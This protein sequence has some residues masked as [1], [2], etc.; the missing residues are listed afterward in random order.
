MVYRLYRVRDVIRIPPDKFNKP[1]EEAAFEEI[2]KT[3]EGAITKNMGV[4]VTVIDVDVEPYGRI[5]MGDGAT[6]HNAEFTLLAFNPF[7]GEVVEGEVNTVLSHGFFV[8]LGLLDGY[9][10]VSQISE[11]KIEYD[12]TRPAL[13]LKQSRKLIEKGDVVRARIYNVSQLKGKGLRIQ[14]TIRQ[15]GMGNIEW[16]KR[17]AGTGESE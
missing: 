3:Y 13:V 16:I 14:M 1:L 7:V 9:V 5:M 17:E 15:P 10:H 6:Y 4:I 2:R 8:D 11:E 12:P